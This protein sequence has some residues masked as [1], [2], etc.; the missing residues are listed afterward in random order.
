MT[1]LTLGVL[2]LTGGGVALAYVRLQRALGYG[3]IYAAGYLAMA[4]GFL[5]L[6]TSATSS[7]IFAGAALVGAGYAAVS[8]TFVALTLAL[9][10]QHRRGTAGGVL[11]ASVFIGQFVSPLLSTPVIN[12]AGY[13]GLFLNT[14]AFLASMA[15]IAMVSLLLGARRRP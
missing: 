9:A 14:A 10:P 13:D 12:S 2:M 5:V 11:T 15:G 1:G 7:Q 4:L 8:P 6:V 3:G